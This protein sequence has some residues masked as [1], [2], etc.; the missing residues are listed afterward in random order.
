MNKKW[1][2]EFHAVNRKTNEIETYISDEYIEAKTL[3]EARKIADEDF[4]YLH[5]IEEW[6]ELETFYFNSDTKCNQLDAYLIEV[7]D[8]ILLS[9]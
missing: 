3:E 4:P 1:L 5:P 6:T 8:T 2:C 7:S 9:N